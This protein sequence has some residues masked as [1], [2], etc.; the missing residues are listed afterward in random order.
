[1]NF[2]QDQLPYD[3][4]GFTSPMDILVAIAN[5]RRNKNK[6]TRISLKD[7]LTDVN[8]D[9]PLLF[10]FVF[11]QSF[12]WRAP[13][14]SG[15]TAMPKVT[16]PGIYKD[17]VNK[18]RSSEFGLPK[19]ET[20][21][22]IAAK[23]LYGQLNTL[24]Y[25]RGNADIKREILEWL[26]AKSFSINDQPVR[27]LMRNIPFTAQFCCEVEEIDYD[28]LCDTINGQ[29][30]ALR[31]AA[32]VSETTYKEMPHGTQSDYSDHPATVWN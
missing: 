32:S 5:D 9:E 6:R 18:G 29:I 2:T 4:S 3:N 22:F 31:E 16:T 20:I 28:W 7:R 11:D 8:L 30:D 13:C 10:D 24:L 23:L 26:F 12:S 14:N 21:A 15:Q 19:V 27:K 25:S 17:I 1:M